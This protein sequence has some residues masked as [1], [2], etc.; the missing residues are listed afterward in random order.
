[1]ISILYF[2]S[3]SYLTH[4]LQIATIVLRFFL[5]SYNELNYYRLKLLTSFIVI[6]LPSIIIFR[7]LLFSLSY[8]FPLTI[9]FCFLSYSVYHHFP[10]V[11]IFSI[12][13]LSFSFS[14]SCLQ[15]RKLHELSEQ[16][17]DLLGLLA[18]QEIEL[19]VF[20]S[21]LN[22]QVRTRYKILFHFS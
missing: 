14:L 15:T 9:I 8:Y 6:I 11:V 4:C 3:I 12:C 1:M 17:T 7:L 16:H 22:S 19:S 18:Q 20:R 21:A 10:S 5:L 13:F 2:A